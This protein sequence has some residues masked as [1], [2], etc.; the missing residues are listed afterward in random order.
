MEHVDISPADGGIDFAGVVIGNADSPFALAYRLR[1]DSEWH[2]REAHLKTTSRH[3]LHIVSNGKGTWHVNGVEEL[4][5]QGCLDIDI[6][7]SPITNTLPIRR[8]GLKPGESSELRLC[9]IAVPD[10]IVTV[11]E[12]RYTALADGLYRFESLTSSFTADLPVDADGL[13]KDYPGL[14]RRIL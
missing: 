8:L 13:V 1:V 5:L 9:Y 10:L 14:F 4:A 12:Q 11:A 6:Q 7:A 2:V 3:G